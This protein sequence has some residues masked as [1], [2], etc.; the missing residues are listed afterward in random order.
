MLAEIDNDGGVSESVV[1]EYSAALGELESICSQPGSE[2]ADMTAAGR[3]L[4]E[5]EGVESTNL[6]ILQGSEGMANATIRN[7]AASGSGSCHTI[8]AAWVTA[9][10][11]RGG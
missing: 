1:G 10:I 5:E 8:I 9:D 7:T 3:K 6:Q 11:A 4:A 2:I